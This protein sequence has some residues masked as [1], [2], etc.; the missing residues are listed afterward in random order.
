MTY[1]KIINSVGFGQLINN[2]FDWL[3]EMLRAYCDK[4]KYAGELLN[5]YNKTY[6]LTDEGLRRYLF[7]RLPKKHMV[8]FY[9]F[10]RG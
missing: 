10:V 8:G 7:A 2:D 1:S 5:T 3:R 9:S 4:Q 6:Q